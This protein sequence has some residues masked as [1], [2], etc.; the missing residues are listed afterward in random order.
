MENSSGTKGDQAPM[1]SASVPSSLV[2]IVPILR[3]AE[4]I[5]KDNPRV[6]YLC[7]FYAYQTARKIDPTY[8][9][10]GV[11]QFMTHMVDRLEKE[12]VE[13]EH[14]LSGSGTDPRE[15]QMYFHRFYLENIA[16]D[17]NKKKP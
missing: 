14:I 10:R 8:S 4:E 1:L 17:Q 15:I 9:G 16:E 11:G 13:T 7:R 2:P 5:E 6:A 12:E 3:V